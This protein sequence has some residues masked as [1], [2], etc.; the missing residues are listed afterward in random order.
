MRKWDILFKEQVESATRHAFRTVGSESRGMAVKRVQ[1]EERSVFR[2]RSFS[3][4]D[5]G[6]WVLIRQSR[7]RN[8]GFE[9]AN[10]LIEPF[11]PIENYL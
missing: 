8:P 5:G 6:F 4:P 3:M 11:I 7:S 1:T 10:C 2:I 9:I